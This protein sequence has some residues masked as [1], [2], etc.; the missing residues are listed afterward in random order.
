MFPERDDPAPFDYHVV[1]IVN[2]HVL[3][4]SFVKNFALGLERC[5]HVLQLDRATCSVSFIGDD[6]RL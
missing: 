4:Y 5:Q 6:L 1:V 3:V 2:V